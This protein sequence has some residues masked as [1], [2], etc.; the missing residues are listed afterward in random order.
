MGSYQFH[1]GPPLLVCPVLCEAQK[2]KDLLLLWA[3]VCDVFLCMCGCVCHCVCSC[4]V[5]CVCVSIWAGL[6]MAFE[7][8]AFIITIPSCSPYSY[9]GLVHHHHSH[10]L[11]TSSSWISLRPASPSSSHLSSSVARK[12][13]RHY[14]QKS[15]SLSSSTSVQPHNSIAT[16]LEPLQSHCP[17]P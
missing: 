15:A 1:M 5:V 7:T 14:H 8:S 16:L 11:I 3:N 4:V 10:F 2:N 6:H 17:T 13:L 9:Q 12:G